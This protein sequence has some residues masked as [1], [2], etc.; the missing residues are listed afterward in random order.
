[1]NQQACSNESL[2]TGICNDLPICGFCYD[3]G[4]SYTPSPEYQMYNTFVIGILM[5]TIG[6]F[7]EIYAFVFESLLVC[8][9]VFRLHNIIYVLFSCSAWRVCVSAPFSLLSFLHCSL[10]LMFPLGLT[11]QSL[12]VF[13]TVSAAFDCFVL[14]I[15]SNSVKEKICTTNASKYIIMLTVL[16]AA[17]FNFPHLFEIRVEY[18]YNVHYRTFSY[19]VCPTALRQNEIYYTLYYAYLYTIVMAAGPV[20]LLIILNSAIVVIMK[21][22]STDQE[23][24]SQSSDITTFV[25]V[26]CLFISC[27]VLPLTVNFMELLFNIANSYLIDL[28]NLMVVLNSSCNFIIYFAFGASF[29]RTLFQYLRTNIL[30][31][32]QT[33]KY[34]TINLDTMEFRSMRSRNSATQPL[35]QGRVDSIASTTQQN[36]TMD[37][38]S[39]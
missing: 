35:I 16:L 26:V 33:L 8:P 12:S 2:R 15:G 36:F 39:V 1:M 28:S 32:T 24:S 25:L 4:Q 38:Q 22:N 6:S 21:Q 20:I 9:G 3:F 14:V 34:A 31:R 7:E 37:H 29:R 11:A 27:N 13:L 19:D 30:R 10:P 5:P 18:C 23:Q 17:I